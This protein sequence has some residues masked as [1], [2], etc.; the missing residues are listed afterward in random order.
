M[1]GPDGCVPLKRKEGHSQSESPLL[2]TT[3]QKYTCGFLLVVQLCTFF[4]LVHFQSQFLVIP[5][6]TRKSPISLIL[7]RSLTATS[8]FSKCLII[9]VQ[10]A[11]VVNLATVD[12]NS[13][14]FPHMPSTAGS[15]ASRITLTGFNKKNVLVASCLPV[16]ES[17]MPCTDQWIHWTWSCIK[18][19]VDLNPRLV[20]WTWILLCTLLFTLS[21][22]QNI[23]RMFEDFQGNVHASSSKTALT[24]QRF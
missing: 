16:N 19:T 15:E 7:V 24:Q 5:G 11:L 6:K 4:V 14:F 23:F 17:K 21:M 12:A 22:S 10:A 20:Q 9:N 8:T 18:L 1:S 3:P 2:S 13:C